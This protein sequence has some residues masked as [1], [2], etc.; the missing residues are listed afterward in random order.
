MKCRQT[1]V[2]RFKTKPGLKIRMVI[3][4]RYLSYS[5]ITYKKVRF[6]ARVMLLNRSRSGD[7]SSGAVGGNRSRAGTGAGAGAGAE[8]A[9]GAGAG[10]GPAA[11]HSKEQVDRR[12]KSVVLLLL[13]LL[14]LLQPAPAS[15]P[16]PTPT[17]PLT[18]RLWQSTL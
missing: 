7:R 5:K 12:L 2:M 4:G 9:A 13:F 17:F 11:L 10:A 15:A 3:S 18:S 14:L 6:A 8:A 1:V 16:A